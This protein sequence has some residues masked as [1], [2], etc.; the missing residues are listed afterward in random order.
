ME[1]HIRTKIRIAKGVKNSGTSG[2]EWENATEELD[3]TKEELLTYLPSRGT[4]GDLVAVTHQD[5]TK[6]LMPYG[7]LYFMK[8]SDIETYFQENKP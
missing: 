1:E 6:F 5:G 8:K 4:L 2:I 7:K 3:I